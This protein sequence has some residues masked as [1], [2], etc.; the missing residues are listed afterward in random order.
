MEDGEEGVMV[1]DSRG[2]DPRKTESKLK[3]HHQNLLLALRV[4]RR[5][6]MF[7]PVGLRMLLIAK[8]SS[9][10]GVGETEGDE[11]VGAE[12]E[13]GLARGRW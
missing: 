4:I 6:P 5:H 7:P 11:W 1:M 12:G 8:E 13:D 2:H 3:Q 10:G 9:Q